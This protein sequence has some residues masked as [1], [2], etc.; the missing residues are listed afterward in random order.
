MLNLFS[1]AAAVMAL[2]AFASSE[3][4]S[5]KIVHFGPFGPNAAGIYEA[6]RDMVRADAIAGHDVQFVDTGLTIGSE[7][8]PGNVGAVDDRGG[9]A[10]K[11][12][13]AEVADSA[14]VLVCH[15]GVPDG[16]IVRTQAPIVWILHG[17]PLAAFRFEQRSGVA[18]YSCYQQVA[19]WPRSKRL[20]HF[21]PEFSP[22]WDAIFPQGKQVALEFP[23]IDSERFGPDGEVHEIEARHR[24]QYNGLI[25]DSWREDVDV[26]EIANGAIEAAK[27]VQGLTWHFYAMEQ[28]LGP[29]EHLLAALRQQGA[30]GEVCGRMPQM[31]QVYRSMDFVLTPHKIV[32]RV[33]GEA[34]CCGTPVIAGRGC[35]VT[36][37]SAAPDDPGS[38]T[39]AVQQLLHQLDR[40]PDAIRDECLEA[41]QNFGLLRHAADMEPIYHAARC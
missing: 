20:V 5:M 33:I 31:E 23:P 21:W 19:Q 38:V 1:A 14:D 11:T 41:A 9:F 16:W 30:L 34:L 32:T 22:Y 39:R 10:L 28:P 15:T 37:F 24:G 26:F 4:H 40:R 36:N 29:W 2:A 3:S 27:R 12:A 35:R 7:R 18:S 8:K 6:A 17:R 13:A 25:C